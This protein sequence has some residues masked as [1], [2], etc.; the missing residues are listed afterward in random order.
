MSRLAD[1]KQNASWLPGRQ[2]VLRGP[3]DDM[4]VALNRRFVIEQPKETRLK[5]QTHIKYILNPAEFAE[6]EIFT[7]Q[8]DDVPF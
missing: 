3:N 6:D 7:E 5:G 2:Y 4:S 1:T 8:I